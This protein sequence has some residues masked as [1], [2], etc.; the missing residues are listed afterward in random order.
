M[1]LGQNF[2][3]NRNF[4]EKPMQNLQAVLY[5]NP[6]AFGEFNPWNPVNLA[7][8]SFT[9]PGN[10]QNGF[11]F[12]AHL[13]RRIFADIDIQG[14]TS[15]TLNQVKIKALTYYDFQEVDFSVH[16]DNAGGVGTMITE[17]N[18]VVPTSIS[19]QGEYNDYHFYE[20]VLDINPIIL[21]APSSSNAKFWIGFSGRNNVEANSYIEVSNAQVVGLGVWRKDND[22]WTY[23]PTYE[24][25]YEFNGNCE[26]LLCE[27]PSIELNTI[28]SCS[29]G[30][31]DVEISLVDLGSSNSVT[32]NDNSGNQHVFNDLGS[33]TFGPYDSG[34]P[35]HFTITGDD[36][37][38]NYELNTTVNCP[39]W[40][41]ECSGAIF[42]E[43]E[44]GVT[45]PT[46]W[47]NASL[48]DAT[49]SGITTSTCFVGGYAD[50]DVWFS[51]VATQPDMFISMW[52]QYFDSV[53]QLFQG[54]C[55]SLVA[56]ACADSYNYPHTT[57]V[58]QGLNVGETYYFRVYSYG[59]Y[60]PDVPYFK[61][62]VWDAGCTTA[63]YTINPV[64]DCE[65]NQYSVEIEV[66]DLGSSETL[67]IS[68]GIIT[69]TI[70]N[71]GV[72]TFGPYDSGTQV[73]FDFTAENEAC[74]MT[75][76]IT[77]ICPPINDECDSAIAVAIEYNVTSPSLWTQ[78][79]VGGAT[80]SGI[81]ARACDNWTGNSNDDVWFSFVA[82]GT[83]VNLT[84]LE[85]NF[86]GI[87]ELFENECDALVSLGCSDTYDINGPPLNHL[88]G[89]GLTI[90]NTYYFRV[91]S[92]SSTPASNPLFNVAVWTPDSMNVVDLQENKL[93][94]LF[95][96]P[97]I[98]QLNIKGIDV[99][100]VKI[101]DAQGRQVLNQSNKNQI[102][103]NSL[104]P[105]IYFIQIKDKTGKVYSEKLLKK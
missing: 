73:E 57:I 44:S 88:E 49:D 82:T 103:M 59:S 27:A 12:A 95:P 41:D 24:M 19:Y 2:N 20:I 56:V 87:I 100:E 39:I 84:L 25:A 38:C 99:S 68:D 78:A 65:S 94:T 11:S 52:E 18:G 66:T 61:V 23:D 36:L 101:F 45:A 7:A 34:E 77:F 96:N 104:A 31:F 33:I 17:Q 62:A 80:Y 76:S 51:F 42:V 79:T 71:T 72:F 63:T 92:Y 58:A 46:L 32:I 53:V 90:G 30:K 85:E 86:D 8:C 105:G 26:D 22:L 91:Y 89:T 37:E 16:L 14:G 29:T 50:D 83:E 54:T 67:G 48:L 6:F 93:V 75:D 28:E 9:N 55:D 98:S 4:S 64:A 5:E 69:Q 47:K 74:N 15:L 21:S 40:N 70:T 1:L 97:V 3:L 81:P 35:A 102:D 43:V 60:I 13:N 10:F